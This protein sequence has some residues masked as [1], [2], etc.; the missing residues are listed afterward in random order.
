M[1]VR[2]IKV[3]LRR[4]KK[5]LAA[6]TMTRGCEPVLVGRAR[7][8]TLRIPA[9]D[10]AASG[11]HAKVFWKGSS[12]MIEDAGSR[13]GVY[14]DGR[15]LKGAH[16][17]TPGAL[18]AV[19]NCLLVIQGEE[20]ERK[21]HKCLPFHRLEFL[22]GDRA[23]RIV[24][25]RPRADGRDFDIGL[26]PQSSIHLNDMLVSRR[27]A[28]L[29]MH[30]DGECWIEDVGSRNGTFVNGERLSGKE[31]LLKDGDKISIAYFEFEFLD[32]KVVHTRVQAWLK[33]G[34][35]SITLC[36]MAAV[37]VGWMAT[38]QSSENYMETARRLAATEN[39]DDARA[40][41]DGARNSRD[42]SSYQEQL[43]ALVLQIETWRKTC[44]AW[45]DV[46]KD[47]AEG[48]LRSARQVL[49]KI[50]SSPIEAWSWNPSE[51]SAVRK[52]VEFATMALRLYFTGKD[53]IDAASGE[54]KPNAD[55]LVRSAIGP[56]ESFLNQHGEDARKRPYIE[57]VLK[58][59]ED[60]LK[61]LR[62]I[63]EGYDAVDNSIARVS[64]V[65]P[66][67]H[68]IY[69]SFSSLA[70][71]QRLPAAVRGYARQQLVP[72]KAFVEAQEFLENEFETLLKL[73]FVG[74]RKSDGDFKL[75]SPELCIRHVKYSDARAAFAAQHASYQ[76]EAE[77]LNLMVCGLAS[78]GI[79]PDARGD[80]INMFLNT[81]N[82]DE[83]LSFDC[84]RRRPP[85]ARRPEPIGMY[86]A[87][88]GIEHV[89]ESLRALPNAL[90]GRN[91]RTVGFAPRCIAARQAF[92]RAEMFVQYL[93]GED[94]KYLQRGDVGRFYTQCVRIT[95]EREN[96]VQRFKD[97]KG[98]ERLEIVA[99][100]F[101]DYFSSQPTDV[102]KRALSLRFAAL[103][104]E[105]VALGERYQFETDPEKQLKLRDEIIDRGI[106]GDPV[107]HSKWAQKFD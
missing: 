15:L 19:G 75:P 21:K 48:R 34:V 52:D 98:S 16:K 1:S 40:A 45:R 71:D 9:D 29:R 14:C 74:V 106:P 17:M 85:N 32:R 36:V 89:Y 47:V 44:Q 94:K 90:N 102:A 58:Q 12:L 88:F 5:E 26:D 80:D 65:K 43:D 57:P 105:L 76:Q 97:K 61:E 68:G 30:D 99:G 60:L 69:D 28:V 73:D 84:L 7:E 37:Y 100:Y 51:A 18:F 103:K 22:N 101:A 66:E 35:V 104:R 96:M 50:S 87:L 92:D 77:S 82:V 27:H 67:F 59:A 46:R 13:N 83:A 31:R 3:I 25:V 8:C 49:D 38:R 62:F 41:V 24:D 20:K 91:V 107:M 70:S 64:A 39:F 11:V 93:D 2:P 78:V 54:S 63:R 72:C 33:L 53:A 95:I 42:A 23:G 10:Y 81:T 6:A 86:D 79:T 55:M 4:E 56:I